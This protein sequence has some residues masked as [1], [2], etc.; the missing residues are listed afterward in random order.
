MLGLEVLLAQ[1]KHSKAS[2]RLGD[3][4]LLVDKQL[5]VM[6]ELFAGFVAA[7]LDLEVRELTDELVAMVVTHSINQLFTI[8]KCFRC[9]SDVPTT[10][11]CLQD[12]I[13]IVQNL[14]AY[15]CAVLQPRFTP[16]LHAV[17]L[18][19]LARFECLAGDSLSDAVSWHVPRTSGS[20]MRQVA[21]D[22]SLQEWRQKTPMATATAD[23]LA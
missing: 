21:A 22:Q 12:A 23:K 9:A 5:G 19:R 14:H 7:D 6:R 11:C 1:V 16:A 15:L 10:A 20:V 4:V 8:K 17:S 3:A 13:A 18:Q 2:R